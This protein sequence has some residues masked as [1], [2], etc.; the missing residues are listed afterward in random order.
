M[1]D[2]DMVRIIMASCGYNSIS[3]RF[4][5]ISKKRNRMDKKLKKYREK[6]KLCLDF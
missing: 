1:F 2:N 6:L 3:E 5:I 4:N